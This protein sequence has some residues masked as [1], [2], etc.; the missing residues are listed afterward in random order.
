MKPLII[1]MQAFGPFAARQVIDFGELGSKTFFLIHG[2][3]G[4][5]KTSILDGICFAL[6]GDSSG[7]E[8]DGKQMRSHHAEADLLTEVSFNFALGAHRYRVRRV[9]EQM[10]KA[11]RGGGET[12]EPQNAELW[13]IETVDGADLKRPMASGW[14]KVTEAIVQLLGFQSQQFRQVIMLPQGKFFEFLKSSSQDREKIL[15]TLFGTELYKRIEEHLKQSA[16][17]LSHQADKVRTRRETLLQQA[18]ADNDGALEA[19]QQQQADELTLRKA[20]EQASANAALAAERVLVEARR[21]A[22]LFT[23]FDQ[24]NAARQALRTE[25]PSWT[26]QQTR[27]DGAR[28]AA[29]IQPHAATLAELRQQLT[30]EVDRGRKLSAALVV[31]SAARTQADAT[32]ALVRQRGP[33]AEQATTRIAEITGLEGQ[34]AALATARAGHAAAQA[35]STQATAALAAAQQQQAAAAAAQKLLAEAVQACRVQAAG[36]DGFRETHARL[37]A[38][39]VQVS[40]LSSRLADLQ[41]ST[42]LVDA[43]RAALT[44]AEGAVNAARSMRDEVRRAWIGGQAA[45]LAHELADG[46]PCPVC[47][48]HEHPVPALASGELVQDD[49]LKA[50][51]EMLAAKE[52]AQRK[53]EAALSTALLATGALDAAIV[54]IRA[55]LGD[56]KASAEAIKAAADAAD[57]ARQHCAA[58]AKTLATQEP[59][60]PAAQAAALNADAALAQADAAARQSQARLQQGETLI[61]EREAGIPP[62]LASPAALQVAK[63]AAL[64]LR[65]DLKL[66][67]DRATSAANAANAKL[68]ETQA[69]VTAHQQAAERLTL[70]HQEKARHLEVRLTTAG[71][72]DA[73]SQQA[74]WLEDAAIAKLDSQIK[75]F[76]AQ[77]A[78]CNDRQQRATAAAGDLNRPD[79][80]AASTSHEAAKLAQQAASH[81]VRDTLAA[82]AT[83]AD[84]VKSLKTLAE[85]FKAVEA[86]YAVLKKVSDVAGGGNSQRMSLQ[87]YVL[88]TLLEEVL[89]ATTV[90]LNVM[91]R[92]RYE[93]RRKLQPADQ[94]AAAGLDLEVFD[95]YTGTTRAVGTLSGG[96]SFLASLALALGLSDVVQAYAGGIRL[97]AIFVDEGFG[98]LDPEALDHAIRALKDLQQA[99]R[100]VGIISHVAELKEWIDARLEL[101]ATQSGSVAQFVL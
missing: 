2:P 33:E 70:Q 38:Q 75:A 28:R 20:A 59:K 76:D 7:G 85:E 34:V 39:L 63:A 35:D 8:R 19:R 67:L 30:G 10:R 27:L 82:L 12:K 66:A 100:M 72:A 37:A 15:Q 49:T 93:M 83:T 43:R 73:A 6:F 79:L 47:G 23:E 61:A 46:Q 25:Q 55:A 99:G 5:G 17:A 101:K 58:A 98:T 13:R 92:G 91:S 52:T 87:R 62:A 41:Q 9:P 84:F 96:E 57:R 77:L 36:L 4:S 40:T 95:Q 71:F 56:N 64:K 54:E 97:D 3:T 32:L 65:D 50:A 1:E 90:R 68:A 14:S 88:A 80:A 31:A 48:G 86:R 60:L 26:G 45:R 16:N 69:L 42:R 81:A 24:S 53:A 94:R 78:S 11:K 22:A 44:A 21:V 29:A 74:A 18:G 51:E 89:V